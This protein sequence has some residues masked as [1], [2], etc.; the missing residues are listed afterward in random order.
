M[1]AFEA[2]G[3]TLRYPARSWSGVRLEDGVVVLALRECDVE[4]HDEGFSCLLWAPLIEGVTPW[5]DRPSRHERLEHC[6]LALVHGGADGLL[7]CGDAALVEPDA[8]LALRVE[9]RRDEYWATWGFA[10]RTQT[11]RFYA[12]RI[13]A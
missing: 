13:A 2:Q 1:D 5:V 11:P 12:A 3:V 9:K 8:M 10:A 7:V 4:G 6:R